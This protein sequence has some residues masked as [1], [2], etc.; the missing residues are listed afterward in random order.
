MK[1]FSQDSVTVLFYVPCCYNINAADLSSNNTSYCLHVALTLWSKSTIQLTMQAVKAY[2]P[3]LHQQQIHKRLQQLRHFEQQCPT[4]ADGL[5]FLSK[6]RLQR[7]RR[8]SI[9]FK[10]TTITQTLIFYCDNVNILVRL[11]AQSAVLRSPDVAGVQER[12]T[13]H[14][15]ETNLLQASSQSS[16]RPPSS[17]TAHSQSSSWLETKLHL[18]TKSSINYSLA[19]LKWKTI[20]WRDKMVAY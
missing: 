8:I 18:R 9:I 20:L 2:S 17:S 13:L 7:K 6:T 14:R 10:K 3:Y 11:A 12:D 16:S 1:S 15:L 4:S 5:S 19:K